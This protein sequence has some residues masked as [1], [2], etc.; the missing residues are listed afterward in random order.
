VNKCK[1]YKDNI[2]GLC[3]FCSKNNDP[4][5]MGDCIYPNGEITDKAAI[6]CSEGKEILKIEGE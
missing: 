2:K 6:H 4:D 1:Y 3:G 5:D